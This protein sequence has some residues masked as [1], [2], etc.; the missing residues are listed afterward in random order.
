MELRSALESPDPHLFES[1]FPVH[2]DGTC[3]GLQHYAAL[4]GDTQGANQVNLGAAERPSDVYTYVASMV[5]EKVKADA[6]DRVKHAMMLDGKITRKV[7]KQTVMTTVYGVTFIGARDQIERQLKERKDIPQEECWLAAS[8]L[9][10]KVMECIGD[11][12]SGAKDIQTWL[13]LCA[14]LISKSIP[15]A[16][17]PDALSPP[18]RTGNSKKPP[19]LDRIKD[20]Q[21]TSVVWTTPLGLPIVQ[22]YRKTKRRQVATTLQTVYISDPNAPAMVNA[23]KQASAFPPNFIHSLDATHMML[24]ALEC[25]VSRRNAIPRVS[26]TLSP[27]TQGLTFASV[28]DSYWTHACSTDQMS[29]IIRDTFIALHSSNILGKLHQ[30]VSESASAHAPLAK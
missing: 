13:N 16:R 21:M 29:A 7:V 10:K 23:M 22:P 1:N 30:E 27:Q 4:G 18:K 20:E 28:H 5:Q 2:Q 9:A 24:T 17:I 11:L 12:F 6:A 19:P 8:Y 3:N 26:L 25:Q 15:P 14:K